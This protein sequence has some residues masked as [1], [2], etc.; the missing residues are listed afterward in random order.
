MFAQT[1]NPAFL[2]HVG[3]EAA[4]GAFLDGIKDG[5]T[6]NQLVPLLQAVPGTWTVEFSS[7]VIDWARQASDAQG[8]NGRINWLQTVLAERLHP[9]TQ[10][11]LSAWLD[12]ARADENQTLQRALRNVIQQ[13]S[14]RTS[15]DKAFA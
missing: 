8:A 13:L 1:K 3:S 14:F 11:A 6:L 2:A 7:A 12:A 9:S 15:I 4:A 10:T 5:Q